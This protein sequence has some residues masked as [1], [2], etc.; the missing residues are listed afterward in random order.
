M[1]CIVVVGKQTHT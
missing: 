1:S